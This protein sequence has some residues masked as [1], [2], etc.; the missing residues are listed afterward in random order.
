[1]E[2]I[3]VWV[4]VLA[5]GAFVVWQLTSTLVGRRGRVGNCCARGCPTNDP[6]RQPVERT[7]FLPAELL[8][9]RK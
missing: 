4:I 3:L 5:C 7:V 6:S 9:K 8:R 2:H 1:M